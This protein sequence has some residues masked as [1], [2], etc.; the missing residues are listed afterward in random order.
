MKNAMAALESVAPS[1][2]PQPPCERR[3]DIA[4]E[5]SELLPKLVDP[6]NVHELPM[7]PLDVSSTA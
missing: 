4:D 7:F 3:D 5:E 1:N 2:T 6:R